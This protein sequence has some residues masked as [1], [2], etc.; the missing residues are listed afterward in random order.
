MASSRGVGV[1]AFV[2]ACIGLAA[3]CGSDD[4]TK[5][6]ADAGSAGALS[7]GG[8][9]PSSGG[10]SAEGGSAAGGSVGEGGSVGGSAEG[11]SAGGGVGG[12]TEGGSTGE[13][14][15]SPEG[16]STSDGGAA[17]QAGAGGAGEPCSGPPS[18]V[19][20][21]VVAI[22]TESGA[23]QTLECTN[24]CDEGACLQTVLEEGWLLHQF[25]LTDD[26][27]DID[28][29]YS[30]SDGGLSALQTQN[31]LPSIYYLDKDLENVIIRGSFGV[32][33]TADDDLIGFVFGLQD[34][35]HFYLF[36]WKQTGQ[37]DASCGNAQ[38]G[39]SLKLVSAEAT[40]E[41]CTD[42][43]SSAADTPNMKVLVPPT[44]NPTGWLDDTLYD[45]E[46][47]HSPGNISI[48]VTLAGQTVVSITSTD[49]TYEHGRFGFYNYS[50]EQSRYQFFD[51]Q[52]SG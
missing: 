8:D 30:F 16:G 15:G 19:S 42:F 25:Q 47:R 50:Q 13:A 17:G 46:L 44:Q 28:A 12:G 32:Q 34:T 29:S 39:A 10:S 9:G 5:A 3:A 2:S 35:E 40:L 14:G 43:W 22:C 37:P 24:G 1:V 38:V 11:G 31:A 20:E 51:I 4:E 18:C 45:F 26:S 41:T 21:D 7:D 36:D 52:P 49:D 33:T 48:R 23:L 27:S 6:Q